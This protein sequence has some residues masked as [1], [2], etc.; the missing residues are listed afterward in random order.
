MSSRDGVTFH[1]FDKAV[2]PQSAP[3]NRKGNRSNYMANGLVTI[4]G[5]PNEYAVYATEAY[6][7]GPD[8]RIRRFMYRV[9]GFVSLRSGEQG[10]EVVT[11]PIK[12]DGDQL[13]LNYR[14]NGPKESPGELRVELQTED[15][16]PIEGYTAGDCRPLTGDAIAHVVSWKQTD[17]VRPFAWKPIRLRFV[18]KNSDLY[19]MRFQVLE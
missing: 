4:P 2:I 13:V 12:F 17:S 18:G 19:S 11:K 9:D 10:G 5:H 6:Y 14:V 15:G 16:Q 7:T 8:S 3:E 1:R